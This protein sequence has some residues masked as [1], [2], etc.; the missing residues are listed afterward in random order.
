MINRPSGLDLEAV[1]TFQSKIQGCTHIFSGKC[2]T[3]TNNKK[4][5]LLKITNNTCQDRRLRTSRCFTNPQPRASS[6]ST[7]SLSSSSSC[8]DIST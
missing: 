5:P 1:L 4:M 7:S 3:T 2:V 8:L 6:S